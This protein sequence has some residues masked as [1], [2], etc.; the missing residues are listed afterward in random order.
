MNK[1]PNPMPKGEKGAQLAEEFASSFLEKIEKMRL[2]FLNTDEYIPEVNTSVLMLQHLLP[3]T[4]EEIEREMLS[5]KNKICELD[6]IPTN[7]LKNTLPTVLETITQIVNMS[8]TTGTF[9]LDRNSAIVRPLT[10][11]PD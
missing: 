6:T 4:I 8:L 9:P 10:K 2:Q 5:M 7:L 3:M 1:A 11:R